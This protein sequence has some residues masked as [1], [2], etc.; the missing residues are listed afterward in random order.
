M[1]MVLLNDKAQDDLTRVKALMK[2]KGETGY[3]YSGAINFVMKDISDELK[4]ELSKITQK[5]IDEVKAVKGQEHNV[6]EN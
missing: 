3:T 5:D 2:K 4:K 6:E 1:G